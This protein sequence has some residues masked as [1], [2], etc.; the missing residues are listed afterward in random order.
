M[1][2]ELNDLILPYLLFRSHKESMTCSANFQ[3]QWGP[4]SRVKA[5]R[6]GI[7]SD[8]VWS[9]QRETILSSSGQRSQMGHCWSAAHV[10][11]LHPL[12]RASHLCA[13][14]AIKQLIICPICLKCHVKAIHLWPR[15]LGANGLAFYLLPCLRAGHQITIWCTDQSP[16]WEC[17][18]SHCCQMGSPTWHASLRHV[19]VY[20]HS[21]SSLC[22]PW[23]A[24]AHA[25]DVCKK[26]CLCT[27]HSYADALIDWLTSCSGS[28][29]RTGQS[30]IHNLSMLR[31]H[32]V[33]RWET[34][35]ACLS[36][37][38]A[39]N[40]AFSPTASLMISS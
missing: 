18:R 14:H 4:S 35:S 33:C 31:T 12:Q 16:K 1:T 2:L 37:T 5:T 25:Q 36:C 7:R 11:F 39:G 28:L 15:F 23:V 38:R 32:M 13:F 6:W 27:A 9:A 19:G 20:C 8:G 29:A 26:S 3:I 17:C 30:P 34:C 24:A 10:S 22:L 21:R 40:S